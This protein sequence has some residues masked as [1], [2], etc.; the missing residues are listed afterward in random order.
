MTRGFKGGAGLVGR[1][2][3]VDSNE[4]HKPKSDGI[5]GKVRSEKLVAVLRGG[6]ANCGGELSGGGPGREVTEGG[7]GRGGRTGISDFCENVTVGGGAFSS[8]T[9]FHSDVSFPRK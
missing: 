3:L 7:G 4:P 9:S 1:T 8:D 5:S 2:F 6:G